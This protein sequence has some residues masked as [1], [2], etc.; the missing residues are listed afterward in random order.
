MVCGLGLVLVALRLLDGQTGVAD[1]VLLGLLAGVGWWSSPEIVYYVVPAMA[2]LGAAVMR[3][4]RDAKWRAGALIT[5]GAAIMGSFPWL[6]SN[7]NSG[8]ASLK[9][10][11]NASHGGFANHLTLFVHYTLPMLAGLRT[12]DS[13]RWI[14]NSPSTRVFAR[15]LF[16][17]VLA[18]VAALLLL[19]LRRGGRA[20]A[21]VAGVLLFPILYA[22]SPYTWYWQDG[23]YASYLVPLLALAI[24]VGSCQ[25]VW[26]LKGPP[27]A[28]SLVM[29]GV[30]IVALVLGVVGLRQVV[31]VESTSFVSRWGNPDSS[32]LV[33]I[34]KLEAGGVRTG[35]ADY[36]VAYKLDFLSRGR[37]D[38]ST[39][40]HDTNRSASI[41][42]AVA[43]SA[44]PAWLFVPGS[45]ATIDGTQFSASLAIVGPDGVTEA[46]FLARLHQ[47]GIGY[48][49]VDAQIVRAVIPDQPVSPYAPGL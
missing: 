3:S 7:V 2:L 43:Q 16:A 40:A 22:F 12:A 29:S 47:L 28:E 49:V 10:G 21:V 13:G 19:C 39:G 41:T 9:T 27:V 31:H 30:V 36:W 45:E 8:L 37:L 14:L 46:R 48:R 11:P 6:W 17:V 1:F 34:R 25:A 33:A 5:L 23:R 20:L 44:S 35:Y 42:R 32:T 26:L 18:V 4:R 24:S 38:I 15:I